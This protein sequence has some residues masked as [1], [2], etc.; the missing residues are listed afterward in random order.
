MSYKW[1]TKVLF[2]A[3]GSYTA[4]EF[5]SGIKEIQILPDTSGNPAS[6]LQQSGRSRKRASF[7]VY[8]NFTEYELLNDDKIAATVR[9]FEDLDGRTFSAVI[10]QLSISQRIGTD[11]FKY[12]IT[13]LEV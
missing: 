2:V 10:E 6:V 9:I 7:D 8:G 3:K 11:Y 5:D 13:L 1:G 12:N 4:P